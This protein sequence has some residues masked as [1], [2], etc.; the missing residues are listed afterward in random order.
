MPIKLNKRFRRASYGLLIG[1]AIAVNEQTGYNGFDILGGDFNIA[2]TVDPTCRKLTDEEIDLAR[3]YFG[4]NVDYSSINYFNRPPIWGLRI[5]ENSIAVSSLGNIFETSEE[6]YGRA[7]EFRKDSVLLHE[8]MHVWQWQHGYLTRKSDRRPHDGIYEYDI[9]EYENFL[10]FGIEQQ[11]EIIQSIHS[12]RQRFDNAISQN[13]PV[14]ATLI[15]ENL[16]THE[17]IAAQVLP[18]EITDCTISE[19]IQPAPE[20]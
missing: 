7:S 15:C 8:I 9:A 19:Q 10:D 14:Q 13:S 11:G 4:D 1:A 16:N 3:E 20:I 5:K 18:I 2:C 17:N 12:L 6:F